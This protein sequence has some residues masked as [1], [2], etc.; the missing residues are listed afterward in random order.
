[1]YTPLSGTLFGSGPHGVSKPPLFS[2]V[3]L[4]FEEGFILLYLLLL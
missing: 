2:K 3:S 4:F 1:M